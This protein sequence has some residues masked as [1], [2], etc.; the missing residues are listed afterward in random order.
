MDM[1]E[2]TG[3]SW[4]WAIGASNLTLASDQFMAFHDVVVLQIHYDN[5]FQDKITDRGSGV[6]L[7]YTEKAPTNEIEVA[8]IGIGSSPDGDWEIEPGYENNTIVFETKL[9]LLNDIQIRGWTL[10]MHELGVRGRMEIYRDGE[11]VSF[12]GCMGYKDEF[13]I[14]ESGVNGCLEVNYDFDYQQEIT[15]GNAVVVVKPGDI[16]RQTCEY[17]TRGLSEP[18]QS[19]YATHE[20]MCQTFI[21]AFPAE[22]IV[23]PFA[24]TNDATLLVSDGDIKTD[25]RTIQ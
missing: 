11:F 2:V 19:G 10:H 12:I 16:L 21:S 18:T 1:P 8:T 5:F 4:G 20:E 15:T 17:D 6:R 9:P 24:F 7:H 22:N 3:F 13:G 14:D 23:S 25:R